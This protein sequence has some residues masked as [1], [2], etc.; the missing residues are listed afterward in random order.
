[1][2]LGVSIEFSRIIENCTNYWQNDSQSRTLGSQKPYA[3]NY[4]F[5]EK[6][7]LNE[8]L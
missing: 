7:N 5:K 2:I 1:M 4:F 6:M 3:H 8:R